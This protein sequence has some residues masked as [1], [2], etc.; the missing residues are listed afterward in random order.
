[1]LNNVTKQHSVSQY[2]FKKIKYVWNDFRFYMFTL[3]FES[4][5]ALKKY[6]EARLRHCF[7]QKYSFLNQSN[8]KIKCVPNFKMSRIFYYLKCIIK[9]LHNFWIG[10]VWHE[11]T[12]C[13]FQI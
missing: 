3:S 12:D 8:I 10:T 2:W 11:Y 1:M 4:I 5:M 7:A 6:C 13:E 9:K